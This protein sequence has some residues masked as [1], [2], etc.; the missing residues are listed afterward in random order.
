MSTNGNWGF[1]KDGVEKITYQHYDSYP[2]GLG[3]DVVIM[4]KCSLENL[5]E[6]F[7]RIQVTNDE[8]DLITPLS[9]LKRYN[10]GQKTIKMFGHNNYKSEYLDYAYIIDLNKKML[11][12]YNFGKIIHVFELENIRFF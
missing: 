12:V 3:D 7:D 9:L 2:S 4:V 1:R 11:E 8:S 6:M 10:R 5:D